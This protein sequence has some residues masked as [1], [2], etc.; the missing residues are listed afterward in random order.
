MFSSCIIYQNEE[1]E[2][3]GKTIEWNNWIRSIHFNENLLSL[4]RKYIQI[5]NKSKVIMKHK[6][7]NSDDIFFRLLISSVNVANGEWIEKK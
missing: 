1:E 5:I 7:F 3:E 2:E 4:S 6:T